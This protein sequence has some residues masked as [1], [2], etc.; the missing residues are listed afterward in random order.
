MEKSLENAKKI[1]E[2][3]QHLVFLGGAGVST[4]SGIQDFRS[5]QGLYNL[6][7][8]YGVPYEE[9]LSHDYF[10]N[11]FEKFYEFYWSTMVNAKAKPN[12][13]H[14]ALADYEKRGHDI[15]IITQN[16]DGLHQMAGSKRVLEVHGAVKSYQCIGCEK[17]FSLSDIVRQGVPRCPVCHDILKPDV[18]LYGEP[19]NETVIEDAV[20]AIE[21]ADT[22]IIGG[23]SLRVYPCSGLV[24]YFLGD[25]QIMI[26]NEPT[27]HDPYCKVVIH[28]DIGTVL[29]AILK[30]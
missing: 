20:R 26:N 4:A 17:R 21:N 23:T 3:S 11:N 22:M 9:M 10:F 5:P 1:I 16:I 6:K 27:D 19:L 24:D 25:N 29:E 7:S 30:D 8:K 12:Q 15:T 14:L 2:Q 18:V 13:A 28:E